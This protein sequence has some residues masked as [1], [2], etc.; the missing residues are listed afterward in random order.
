MEVIQ[1]KKGG[2]RAMSFPFEFEGT[3]SWVNDE[4]WVTE[5]DG[6]KINTDEFYR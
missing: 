3:I 1:S 4:Y 5:V 2:L 6:L